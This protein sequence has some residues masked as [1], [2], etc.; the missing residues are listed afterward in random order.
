MNQF[1]FSWAEDA[2]GKIVHIDDVPNGHECNCHCPHCKEPLIAR[3]G[4]NPPKIAHCFAHK[5]KE[6]KAN[7]EMCHKVTM[8]KLAEQT[9]QQEKMLR[10]PSYYEIFKE[11]DLEFAEVIIDSRYE[12]DDK[13]PDVIATTTSGEQYLITFTFDHKPLHNQRI[14]YHNLNCIEVDLS[15]QTYESLK[16]FLLHTNN[17][18]KWLNNQTSFNRI[19]SVYAQAGKPVKVVHES[20][21]VNCP[22]LNNCCGIRWNSE[23]D[24]IEIENN[25]H[26]YRICKIQEFDK[27]KQQK[28]EELQQN[29]YIAHFEKVPPLNLPKHTELQIV[30]NERR[31]TIRTEDTSQKYQ[32]QNNYEVMETN[33]IDPDSRTCFMCKSNLEW[34]NRN[35]NRFAHCGSFKNLNVPENTPP[36]TAKTCKGFRVKTTKLK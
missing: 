13:Q 8:Y 25:G 10:A 35:N 14:D 17:D 21:C 29:E 20:T 30:E 15:S 36:D 3:N 6:R 7:R 24:L 33:K 19:E 27:L 4:T 26:L 34:K 31:D 5:S 1:V 9:I 11:T 32:D 16:H 18:R 28:E 2:N 12:R 23:S 22:I